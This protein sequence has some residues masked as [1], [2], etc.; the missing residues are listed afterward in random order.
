MDF[1]TSMMKKNYENN[2]LRNAQ[3]VRDIK[4]GN[5]GHT[6]P[7]VALNQIE[8]GMALERAALQKRSVEVPY[9]S[10]HNYQ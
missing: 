5:T 9:F 6:R 3:L 8:H 10:H 4:S 1:E 7:D 2:F